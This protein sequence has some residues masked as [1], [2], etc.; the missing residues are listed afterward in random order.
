[1]MA[2]NP[3]A[4]FVFHLS[5]PDD[6]S[7]KPGPEWPPAEPTPIPPAAG[8]VPTVSTVTGVHF[9]FFSLMLN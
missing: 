6:A 5:E 8:P 3:N 1:M 2:A 7:P 9:Q 4:Y